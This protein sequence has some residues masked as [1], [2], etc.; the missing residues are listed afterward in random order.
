MGKIVSVAAGFGW[1]A[2]LVAAAS[3]PSSGCGSKGSGATGGSD[4][5]STASEGG[6]GHPVVSPDAGPDTG[7]TGDAAVDATVDAPGVVCPT[8]APADLGAP[9]VAAACSRFVYLAGG[10]DT[11]VL[12]SLDEGATW[13]T[14]LFDDVAGDD[15]VNN[16]AVYLGVIN[17]TTLPGVFQSPDD[18]STFTVVGAIPHSNFD[19]YGG[20]LN[21]GDKGLLLTDNQGTYSTLDGVTWTTLTPFPGT[22][23]QDGFGGHWSGT[24]FG[25]GIYVALQDKAAFRTWDGTT[26]TDGTLPITTGNGQLVAFG[27]GVFVAVGG[28]QSASSADGKTW[29]NVSPIQA[30]GD[31]GGTASPATLLFDGTRFLGYDN[32]KVALSADGK[33][34]TIQSLGTTRIETAA[35]AEGHFVAAGAVGNTKGVLLSSDGLTWTLSH[36]FATGETANINGWRVGV[37]RVLK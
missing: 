11:R 13:T 14:Q 1:T 23:A 30:T 18:G 34:W 33:T 22:P 32:E 6:G 15:Y 25:A 12:Q 35:N 4:G 26:F 20:Q 3:A 28:G 36:A 19:T 16:L 24:A 27:N 29:G 31:G 17:T 2:L 8:S 21:V 37:G 7:P 10:D 5:G 9:A